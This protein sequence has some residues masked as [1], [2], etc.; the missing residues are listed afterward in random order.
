MMRILLLLTVVLPFSSVASAQAVVEPEVCVLDT[1][2]NG[3]KTDHPYII[4]TNCMKQYLR[5]VEKTA[6][7]APAGL[8]SNST[9]QWYAQMPATPNAIAENIVVNLKNGSP[10]RAIFADVIFYNKKTK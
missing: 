4:H 3:A 7:A 1:L 5:A 10:D 8:F 2:R 9:M 6:V